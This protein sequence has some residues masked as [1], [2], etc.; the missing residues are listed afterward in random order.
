MKEK[1]TSLPWWSDL[2]RIAHEKVDGLT[3]IVTEND[4]NK[5]YLLHIKRTG[6]MVILNV[7]LACRHSLDLMFSGNY[8]EAVFEHENAHL[9]PTKHSYWEIDPDSNPLIPVRNDVRIRYYQFSGFLT[10]MIRDSIANAVLES[11]TLQQFLEFEVGKIDDHEAR[12]PFVI[13]NSLW[14]TEVKLCADM[15]H[16]SINDL[17]KNVSAILGQSNVLQD[18]YV[19][20]YDV[21]KKAW[22][23]SEKASQE[24]DL[25]TETRTL[26]EQVL[27]HATI[28]LEPMRA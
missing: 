7:N 6:K 18:I 9:T 10:E 5:N 3:R 14:V 24:V 15:R 4:P 28:L 17:E 26:R 13:D 27:K 19:I 2:T 12:S 21:F 22:L 1:Q 11:Q 23:A 25:V 16:L 20:A 8:A